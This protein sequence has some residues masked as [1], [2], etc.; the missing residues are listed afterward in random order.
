M[1]DTRWPRP[2][3][4]MAAVAA[5]VGL[6][7]GVI[8][9]FSSPGSEPAAQAGTASATSRPPATTLPDD[10]H[11]VVLGSFD[12]LARADDTMRRLR[13]AGVDDAAV[14]KQSDYPS[15]GTAY[16]VYSGRFKT[17]AEAEA[18]EVELEQL[19]ITDS[20]LKHVTR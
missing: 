2:G 3:P 19:G 1:Y 6:V 4:A 7:A 15:L 14:L 11:T 16:A 5:V 17:K 12:D 20:Y 8:L 9:G 13:D 10:F 18:H